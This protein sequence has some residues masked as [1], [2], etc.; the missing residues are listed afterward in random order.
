MRRG[1]RAVLFDLGGTLYDYQTLAVAEL[2]SLIDLAGCVG[3]EAEPLALQR[4]Y[5]A[6]LR[7]AF[8]T[9]LPQRFYLHRDLFRDAALGMLGAFG[10]RLAEEELQRHRVRQWERH[11]RDFALRDGAVETLRELRARGY[12][13]GIV[14]NIDDDQ[15][16]HLAGM[17]DLTAYFDWLLSSEAAGSCKPDPAIFHEALRRAAC[18]PDEALFVGDTVAQDI[19]GAN[20]VGMCSVLL[21]HRDDRDP[22]ADAP[23]PRHVIRRLPELLE[24]V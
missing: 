3:I 8:H 7:R 22:P 12:Q 5:Q 24:L 21:W 9:Y 2:E 1:V 23:R 6:A 19:A 20:Q 4:A 13:L 14:S 18:R 15:L 11:A 17:A 16:A 10:A